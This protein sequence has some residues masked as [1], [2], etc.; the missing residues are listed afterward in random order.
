MI[1]LFMAGAHSVFKSYG[2]RHNVIGFVPQTVIIAFVA[3]FGSGSCGVCFWNGTQPI[4]VRSSLRV[5]RIW[6]CFVK[7]VLPKDE[8]LDRP[9]IP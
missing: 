5:F 3:R 8:P 7:L 1:S 4:W 6:L 9:V 2:D